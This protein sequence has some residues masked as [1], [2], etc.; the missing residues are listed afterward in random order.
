VLLLIL[1]F[2]LVVVLDGVLD[3][4]LALHPM[5]ELYQLDTL[6]GE[7]GSG[8]EDETNQVLVRSHLIGE[9]TLVILHL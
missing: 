5:N 3:V 8:A 1:G 6:R 2:L 9:T 7:N 4:D